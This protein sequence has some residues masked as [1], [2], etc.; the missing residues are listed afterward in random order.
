MTQ[1][2]GSEETTAA[3]SE[4]TATAADLHTAQE[5]GRQLRHGI[6][7]LLI[8]GVLVVAMLLAVPH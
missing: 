4:D 3:E 6:A 2:E 8:V 5:A 7:W 1:I